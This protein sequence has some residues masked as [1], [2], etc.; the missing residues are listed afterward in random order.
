MLGLIFDEIFGPPKVLP[1]KSA[2]I[3]TTIAKI[4]INKIIFTKLDSALKYVK[5]RKEQET[6]IREICFT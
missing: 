3:S 6:Y 1:I 2:E 4:T 5:K